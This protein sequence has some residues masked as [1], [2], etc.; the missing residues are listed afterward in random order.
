MREQETKRGRVENYGENS[1]QNCVAVEEFSQKP[2]TETWPRNQNH[3]K[4][5]LIMAMFC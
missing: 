1:I 4:W 2:I 5:P 3:H